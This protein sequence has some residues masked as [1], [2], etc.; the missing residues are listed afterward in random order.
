MWYV[1]GLM[2]TDCGVRNDNHVTEIMRNNNYINVCF[3][4]QLMASEPLIYTI[5][6]QWI[7]GQF[8]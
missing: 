1:Y 6:R 8:L 2:W 7:N 3:A 5:F 4:V